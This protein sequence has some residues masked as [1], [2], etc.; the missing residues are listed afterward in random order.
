MTM[1]HFL[2]GLLLLA[3]ADPASAQGTGAPELRRLSLEELGNI[4]VT[5]VSRSPDTLAHAPAAVFVITQEDI[6]RSGAT[7][8]P[9]ALRLAPGMQVTRI[10]SARWAIGMRGFADRLARSMLVLIDGRAV[11]SPLFAGTYWEV[12]DTLLEDIDR[13]G[14]TP[15]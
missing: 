5:T 12:Q 11:Y 15:K 2:A 14:F 10:D 4:E 3:A 6:R 13:I 7:S 9:E 1:Q 8:I